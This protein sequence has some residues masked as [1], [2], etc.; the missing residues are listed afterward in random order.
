VKFQGSD[1]ETL[2]LDNRAKY[3]IASETDGRVNVRMDCNRG[4]GIWKSVGTSQIEF[5]PL[6]LTRA[7]CPP[8]AL[9]DRLPK[10]WL[11]VRSYLWQHGHLFLSLTGD[12]GVYEFEPL[13]REQHR[14]TSTISALPATFIG[15]LPCADCPGIRYQVDLLLIALFPA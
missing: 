7:M 2:T 9:N 15:T 10:D 1:G 13:N 8:A 12:R 11:Y 3:S 5:G 6:A 14:D 4:H